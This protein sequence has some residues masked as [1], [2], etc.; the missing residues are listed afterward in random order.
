MIRPTKNLSLAQKVE[1][2]L[3][4]AI[5]FSIP[6]NLGKHFILESSYIYGKLV[7]YAVPTLYLQDILI[8]LLIFISAPKLLK[9]FFENLRHWEFAFLTLFLGA[10]LL[11]VF[12]S[13]FPI[14]SWYF[15]ARLILYIIFGFYVFS[16]V[17]LLKEMPILL[18]I[19]SLLL[20][21]QSLL[22]LGQWLTQGSVF[23][24]YLFF[25]EQPYSFSTPNIV[26]VSL[27]G[28]THL[29]LYGTF[30]HPN[31]L[32]GF[33]TFCILFILG[34]HPKKLYYYLS[35]LP[36]V[37]CLFLTFSWLG[38]FALFIGILLLFLPRKFVKNL[39]T[40][41]LSGG[42]LAT[43]LLLLSAK[44]DLSH[45]HGGLNSL[46]SN[47]SI[48]RRSNL[49]LI[50]WAL[51]KEFPLFGV[52]LNNS[53]YYIDK[54]SVAL[55]LPKFTQPIHNIYFLLFAEIGFFAVLFLGGFFWL[56]FKKLFAYFQKLNSGKYPRL[57]LSL[58]IVFLFSAF[59]D[60]YLLTSQ[61][62]LLTFCLTVGLALQYN[63]K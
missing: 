50:G 33:L 54:Y 25:G 51:F 13:S 47:P 15:F 63:L 41:V 35:I 29:P 36:G 53:I 24:N 40:S 17:D 57:F 6:L 45:I 38:I 52:G 30:R 4:Y 44:T 18:K 27:G 59:F 39:F 58:L 62:I 37:L 16:Q 1:K 22:G 34:M 48:Y 14:S 55:A 21:F 49:L 32:A 10:T 8:F 9:T 60:H 61:Q 46:F 31:T 12:S 5:I 56:L 3:F 20:L 11:S 43:I 42:I 19:F 26:R 2:I 23:D 7:D 28:V